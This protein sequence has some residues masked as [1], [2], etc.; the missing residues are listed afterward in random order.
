MPDKELSFV[1]V[2]VLLSRYQTDRLATDRRSKSSPLANRFKYKNTLNWI[3]SLACVPLSPCMDADGMTASWHDE[4]I[5]RP[6]SMGSPSARKG[7]LAW[8]RRLLG[9]Y[10]ASSQA[11]VLSRPLSATIKALWSCDGP[12]IGPVRFTLMGS[13]L[14][15]TQAS[16]AYK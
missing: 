3:Q 15:D 14:C 1:V 8:S 7:S 5:Y 16:L 11:Q 13:L 6:L 4:H 9:L 2:C 12:S 10:V